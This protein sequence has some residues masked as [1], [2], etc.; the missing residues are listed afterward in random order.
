M[1][2]EGKTFIGQKKILTDGAGKRSF[3]FST[4]KA[5]RVGQTVYGT[6]GPGRIPVSSLVGPKAQGDRQKRASSD[7]LSM[8][9][10][11]ALTYYFSGRSDRFTIMNP[12]P[13]S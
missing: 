1:S 13:Y 4:K 7:V 8:V 12:A 6:A 10:R 3:T 5:V 2:N 11:R 9:S